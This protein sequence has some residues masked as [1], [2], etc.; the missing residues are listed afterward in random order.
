M[1]EIDGRRK[2]I[3][4]EECIWMAARCGMRNTAVVVA[5]LGI[6]VDGEQA[7][8]DRVGSE[9]SNIVGA[10][11]DIGVQLGVTVHLELETRRLPEG[12]AEQLE[13]P[14]HN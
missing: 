13:H 11:H 2:R 10:K 6:A 4:G 9:S 8:V 3:M 14:A 12:F 5:A 7:A 1:G